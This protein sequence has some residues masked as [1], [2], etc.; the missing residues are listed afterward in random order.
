MIKCDVQ[1]VGVFIN[2]T[3]CVRRACSDGSMRVFSDMSA[4]CGRYVLNS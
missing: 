1:R 4:S 3:V 2:D